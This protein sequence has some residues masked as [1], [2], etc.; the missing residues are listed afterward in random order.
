MWSLYLFWTLC[1]REKSLFAAGNR[2]PAIQPTVHHCTD[3]FIPAVNFTDCHYFYSSRIRTTHA[4]DYLALSNVLYFPHNTTCDM[5]LIISPVRQMLAM[6]Q[7]IGDNLNN[8]KN[9]VFWVMTPSSLVDRNRLFA[10]PCI[11]VHLIT[12][13]MITIVLFT[14]LWEFQ[15][16]IWTMWVEK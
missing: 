3:C 16:S 6:L 4:Y 9:M 7:S 11:R 13:L 8:N 10:Q 12:S 1:R 15:I 2:T 5:S 14:P